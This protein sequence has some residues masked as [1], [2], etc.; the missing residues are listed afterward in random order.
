[1]PVILVSAA[2][3]ERIIPAPGTDN[4][5]R[6][7]SF[8]RI[9]QGAQ[10]VIEREVWWNEAIGCTEKEPGFLFPFQ[11]VLKGRNVGKF[12]AVIRENNGHDFS[13][14]EACPAQTI[15][16]AFDRHCGR[17]GRLVVQQ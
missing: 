3:C 2:S 8:R 4:A 9:N 15:F 10:N 12:P 5:E 16:Q 1:M 13:K 7:L 14:A 17:S 11:I 6:A